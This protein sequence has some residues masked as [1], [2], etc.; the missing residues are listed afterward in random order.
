[1]AFIWRRNQLKWIGAAWMGLAV[2]T[3]PAQTPPANPPPEVGDIA[4]TAGTLD[5]SGLQARFQDVVDAVS[6]SVVSISAVT[7]RQESVLP[8]AEMNPGRLQGILDQST[9]TVG[10]GFVVGADGWILTNEH[11]VTEAQALWVTT[12]DRRVW[13]ALVVGSDPRAD[14]AVLK[15]PA[16]KLTPVKFADESTFHRGQWTIALGN[17]FG[18]AV[19]GQ[20]CMS[21][22]VVSALDRSLQRLAA[23]EDRLYSRMIETTAQINPGNSGGPLFDMNGQVIGINT[24]VILPQKQTNGVGFAIPITHRLLDE[25]SD[26]EQGR[27]IVYGY[28]GVTVATADAAVGVRV[29]STDH[30]S[31]AASVLMPDD[32]LTRLN[33]QTLEDTD[34][35]VRLVGAAAIGRPLKLELLRKGS[36]MSV[37]LVP[38]H[39]ASP[40]AAVT[41]ENQRLRWRGL[42]LGPL[43]SAGR[44]I[45][46][47]DVDEDS[48]LT[49]QGVQKGSVIE[50]VG[51]RNVDSLIDLLQ[52]ID[53]VPE[54]RCDVS[55]APPATAV[56]AASAEPSR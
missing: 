9:R 34:Q 22:G 51:G 12:S 16:A 30:N 4:V 26:L 10:T 54:D 17:P 40:I 44:G 19:D 15:I 8:S 1:M 6:P 11:V 37:S 50:T 20:S 48:P 2:A 56:P 31:P 18:L 32:L 52:I 7:D 36:A 14:V 29:E 27:A 33:D 49:K 25:V 23:K 47:L 3:A 38:E 42:L 53:D 35:F 55:L 5:L 24:A 39:R 43:P 46:V 45:L 21:V 28:L 13:P 41:R